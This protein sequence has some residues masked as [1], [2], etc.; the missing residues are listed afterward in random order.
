MG[1]GLDA[2]EYQSFR[3]GDQR[4]DAARNAGSV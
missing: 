2:A 4:L 3:R 1:H